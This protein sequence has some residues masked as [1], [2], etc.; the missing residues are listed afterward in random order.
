MQE[1]HGSLEK[2]KWQVRML[3][4]LWTVSCCEAEGEWSLRMRLMVGDLELN[5]AVAIMN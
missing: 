2:E 1:Q 5:L 4:G 3:L